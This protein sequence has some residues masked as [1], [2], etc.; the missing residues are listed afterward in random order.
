MQLLA[1]LILIFAPALDAAA[2]PAGQ[3]SQTSQAAQLL[4]AWLDVVDD[5]LDY[6]AGQLPGSHCN[7]TQLGN[8]LPADEQTLLQAAVASFRWEPFLTIPVPQLCRISLDR[9]PRA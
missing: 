6:R 7:Q 3:A 1:V 2:Q 5:P 4:P 9:P 8:F